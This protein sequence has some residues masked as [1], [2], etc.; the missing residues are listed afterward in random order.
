ML[1]RTVTTG[2]L[3][4]NWSTASQSEGFRQM[5]KRENQDKAVSQAVETVW[6]TFF[7]DLTV[8]IPKIGI[9]SDVGLPKHLNLN[10]SL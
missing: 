1:D 10:V 6:L 4:Y 7:A 3:H 2:S 5:I 8:V 9:A